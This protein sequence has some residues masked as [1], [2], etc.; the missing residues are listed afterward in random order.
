MFI[1][2]N[3]ILSVLRSKTLVP[4][5]CS[6]TTALGEFFSASCVPGVNRSHNFPSSLEALCEDGKS[7]Q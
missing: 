3:S 2:W 6:S 5:T 4:S 1:G 7:I